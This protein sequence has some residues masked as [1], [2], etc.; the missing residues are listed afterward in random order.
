MVPD[1]MLIRKVTRSQFEN[2][3]AADAGRAYDNYGAI[4]QQLVGPEMD[5]AEV[6][7]Q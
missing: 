1:D 7:R 5:P 4:A 6:E 2:M 3:L